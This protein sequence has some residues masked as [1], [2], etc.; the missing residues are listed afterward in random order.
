MLWATADSEY[1]ERYAKAMFS[2]YEYIMRQRRNRMALD[3]DK[4]CARIRKLRTPSF[5]AILVVDANDAGLYTYR[6]RMLRGFVRMQAE[7]H[8]IELAGEKIDQTVK[9]TMGVPSSLS[10]GYYASEPPPGIHWDRE[11]RKD[12]DSDDQ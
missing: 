2:S 3:Y 7:A 12:D 5:G 10:R 4:F 8:G 6:E 1:L 11:R 9:Q